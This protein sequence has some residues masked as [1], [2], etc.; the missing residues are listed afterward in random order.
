MKRKIFTFRR[1][2]YILGYTP[3]NSEYSIVV[4]E[5]L[6]AMFICSYSSKCLIIVDQPNIT[7]N[8]LENDYVAFRGE[9]L[10]PC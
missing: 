9:W 5:I 4:V 2:S 3:I 1:L 7:K 6:I 10:H 8:G